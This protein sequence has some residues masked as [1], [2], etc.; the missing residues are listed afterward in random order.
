MSQLNPFIFSRLP[1][2]HTIN[3]Y[4]YVYLGIQNVS[5]LTSYQIIYYSDCSCTLWYSMHPASSL[6]YYNAHSKNPGKVSQRFKGHAL[7]EGSAYT[8]C[9]ICIWSKNTSGP[10]LKCLKWRATF[11][12]LHVLSPAWEK[13]HS[14]LCRFT[15][16]RVIG[17]A[18]CRKL[19]GTIPSRPSFR[20]ALYQFG[21]W[22]GHTSIGF[23][24]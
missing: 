15:F 21:S 10:V 13:T 16:P 11:S 14:I 5:S 2:Q 18:S 1:W 17:W 22:T 9:L 20:R 7:N 12:V 6:V 8:D 23:L 3:I 4:Y 24:V 19:E